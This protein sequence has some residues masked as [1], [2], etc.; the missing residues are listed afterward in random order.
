MAETIHT[1]KLQERITKDTPTHI[2]FR[3][4]HKI[5]DELC[6]TPNRD[7]VLRGTRIVM[8]PSL[9]AR[10]IKLAHE[11][12]QGLVK[13]KKLLRTKTWF[14]KVDQMMAD[15][16]DKCIVPVRNIPFVNDRRILAISNSRSSKL[17]QRQYRHTS[18]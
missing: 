5:K 16:I 18:V 17:D 8:P 15:G 12:H 6:T 4:Y 7:V 1:G 10:A 3:A 13:S 9:M 11:G 2:P 14:P